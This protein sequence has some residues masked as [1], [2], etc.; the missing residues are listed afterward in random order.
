M[1]VAPYKTRF[2]ACLS[3][4][5]GAKDRQ[6]RQRDEIVHVG[7]ARPV[8]EVRRRFD[9]PGVTLLEIALPGT[10]ATDG[11]EGD[12]APVERGSGLHQL[13]S[14]IQRLLASVARQAVAVPYRFRGGSPDVSGDDTD[15]LR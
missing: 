14:A 15:P 5:Q 9:S 13:T 12:D 10:P 2:T 7:R 6:P 8:H 4:F 11:T 1:A 3:P